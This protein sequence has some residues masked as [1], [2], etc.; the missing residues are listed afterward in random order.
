MYL[1]KLEMR[2]VVDGINETENQVGAGQADDEIVA[3]LSQIRVP[4][5][6]PVTHTR[7]FIPLRTSNGLWIRNCT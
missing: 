1:L 4:H 3:G 2:Q 5:D 6:G 7:T